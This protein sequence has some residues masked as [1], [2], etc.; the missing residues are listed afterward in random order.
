[1]VK[2]PPLSTLVE[3]KQFYHCFGCG[4]SGDVFKFIEEYQGVSFM[5]AVQLL[6][7]RVGIQL[8]MPVQSRFQQASPY[9]SSI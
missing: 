1:M 4:R 8:A 5:E 2:R 3:D 7:E 9:Q 6:G